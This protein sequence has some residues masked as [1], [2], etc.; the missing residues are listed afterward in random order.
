[1]ATTA[2]QIQK[3]ETEDDEGRVAYAG[4][5]VCPHCNNT[6]WVKVFTPWGCPTNTRCSCGADAQRR[7]DQS[8]L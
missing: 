3:N 7:A 5:A 4:T 6:G 8:G 2:S 1:M